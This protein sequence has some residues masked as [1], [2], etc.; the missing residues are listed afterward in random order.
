M[1]RTK[2]ATTALF[3][4]L[5]SSISWASSSSCIDL[6]AQQHSSIASVTDQKLRVTQCVMACQSNQPTLGASKDELKNHTSIKVSSQL[7]TYKSMQT[8]LQKI[9]ER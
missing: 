2:V 3:L 5:F 4:S 9:P 7:S 8:K 1:A 6:C